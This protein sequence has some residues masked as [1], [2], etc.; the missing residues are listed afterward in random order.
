[1]TATFEAVHVPA[2]SVRSAAVPLKAQRLVDALGG[3]LL[4]RGQL[5]FGFEPLLQDRQERPKLRARLLSPS[6]LERL[7]LKA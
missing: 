6:V 1:V 7:P 2:H 4:A 5:L 3:A